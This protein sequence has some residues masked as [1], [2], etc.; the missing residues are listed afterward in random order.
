MKVVCDHCGAKVPKYE[1]VISPE[2][3]KRHC[4]NCFNKK[5]SQELGID[6]ETVNFD[7]IT[8]ED[9][10]GGKHTFHF[11]SL[12][13]PTGKLIEAFE[14]KEG[15]PGGYMSGVLDGFSCDIS[16]LKIKLLNRLQG[17][18]KHKSLEKFL[19]NWTL[20][21]PGVIR[22]RIEY[23]FGE[24]SPIIIIDG[25]YFTWDEFGRMITSYEGWQFRLKMVDK[26]DED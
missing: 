1:T 8:L 2:D 10:Y 14:L 18:M 26:T 4:F 7:P 22:G 24:D 20:V 21:S 5:I 11:R 16:D 9:S 17:L 13:V 6:F 19:G 12:L 25:K 15:E 23:G 3:G